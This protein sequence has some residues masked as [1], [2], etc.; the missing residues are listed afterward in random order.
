[1][2]AT[3][4]NSETIP[5]IAGTSFK[6]NIS[7]VTYSQVFQ[8]S[9][10]GKAIITVNLPREP[11]RDMKITISGDFGNMLIA[12]NLPRC[13]VTFTTAFGGSWDSADSLIETCSTYSFSN[14][15]N[16]IVITTKK[17]VYKCGLSFTK[18]MTVMLWPVNV[19]N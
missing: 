17:M 15:S 3:N 8:E 10:Y 19:V 11:V 7:A 2:F 18:T 1:S 5:N 9:G 13:L 14:S 4:S 16:P 6:A 12:G